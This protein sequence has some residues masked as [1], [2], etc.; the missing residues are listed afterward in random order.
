MVLVQWNISAV[1]SFIETFAK[2]HKLY[3]ST[4]FSDLFV[5]DW[6]IFSHFCTNEP[7]IITPNRP[8]P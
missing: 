4:P 8:F 7:G 1:K 5:S 3:V 6:V 2:S